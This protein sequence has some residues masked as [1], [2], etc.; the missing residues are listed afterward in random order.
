MQTPRLT[1]IDA[2]LDALDA[3]IEHSLRE[4]DPLGYFAVLYR[5]VTAEVKQGIADDFFDDG[6][7][8]ERL[9]VIFARRYIDAYYAYRRGESVTGSWARAFEL[10]PRYWPIVM[11][12]LLIG[13][14]AHINLDLGIAAAETGRGQPMAALQGDFNRINTILAALVEEMQD[15]LARIWPRLHWV[16]QRTGQVDNH[17]VDFSMELARDGAWAFAQELAA[18]PDADWPAR[19]AERDARVVRTA[20]IITGRSW[21]LRAGLGVIRLGER[22][23]VGAKIEKLRGNYSVVAAG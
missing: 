16:L 9:D 10:S 15:R 20:G 2:V 3:I 7:R 6:P 11:Q 4:E 19:I 12:H 14:N 17:L 18:A 22:G 13:I 23:S 1:S 8:M 5:R 21:V